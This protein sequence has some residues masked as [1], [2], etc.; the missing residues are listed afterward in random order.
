MSR[1]EEV[2]RASIFLRKKEVKGELP[3]ESNASLSRK[4]TYVYLCNLQAIVIL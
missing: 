2:L 1:E 3:R 4:V